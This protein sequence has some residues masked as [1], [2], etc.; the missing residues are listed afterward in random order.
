MRCVGGVLASPLY[1]CMCIRFTLRGREKRR[2]RGR[3]GVVRE[4]GREEVSNE[5]MRRD[6][7]NLLQV[8]QLGYWAIQSLVQYSPCKIQPVWVEGLLR[9]SHHKEYILLV[10]LGLSTQ[11]SLTNFAF[12]WPFVPVLVHSICVIASDEKDSFCQRSHR[13]PCLSMPVLG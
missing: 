10:F 2:K 5:R 3:E 6:I 4:E 12:Q 11:Q 13:S 9:M 1:F 8:Y 7:F